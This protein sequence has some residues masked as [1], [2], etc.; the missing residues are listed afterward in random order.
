[1]RKGLS[2]EL[3]RLSDMIRFVD[4]WC[5]EVHVPHRHCHSLRL[6]VDEL[7]SNVCRHGA[8]P[9]DG[10]VSLTLMQKDETVAIEIRDAGTPFNL[11]EHTEP[12][13]ALPLRERPDGGMGLLLVRRLSK[14]LVYRREN[15][16]NVLTITLDQKTTRETGKFFTVAR[17]PATKRQRQ[18]TREV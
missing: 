7:V 12:D 9:S 1:M 5:E 17:H 16:E 4:V 14:G 13:T 3:A 11:L 2:A 8:V 18:S 10:T 15:G 6:I